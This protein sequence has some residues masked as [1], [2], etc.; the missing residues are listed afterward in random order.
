VIPLRSRTPWYAGWRKYFWLNSS[1][2]MWVGWAS[3]QASSSLSR[4]ILSLCYIND[5]APSLAARYIKH[6]LLDLAKPRS[7]GTSLSSSWPTLLNAPSIYQDPARRACKC[8]HIVFALGRS[9]LAKQTLLYNIGHHQPR[10]LDNAVTRSTSISSLGANDL[11]HK[12]CQSSTCRIRY[13]ELP[14]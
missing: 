12:I 8:K 14:E 3:S 6:S 4:R 11:S 2:G 9:A 10:N 5:S 13:Y 1:L 7:L